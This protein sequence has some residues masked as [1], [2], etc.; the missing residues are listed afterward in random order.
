MWDMEKFFKAAHIA[1]NEK[2]SLT[3]IYLFGD[4]DSRWRTQMGDDA[5]S[6]RP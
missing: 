1:D 4:T 2:V 5:E 6:E 3:S